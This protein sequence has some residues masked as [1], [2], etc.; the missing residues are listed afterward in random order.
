MPS[1]AGGLAVVGAELSETIDTT[2]PMVKAEQVWKSFGKLDVLKTQ[3][4][5]FSFSATAHRCF[6]QPLWRLFRET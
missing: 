6:S 3:V 4:V 2:Q 1:D 5:R